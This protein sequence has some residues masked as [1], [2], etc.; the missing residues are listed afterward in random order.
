MKPEEV[1]QY[2]AELFTQGAIQQSSPESWQVEVETMRLL[3]LLSD[4][5]SWLRILAPLASAEEAQPFLEQL[6][7]ANFDLTQETRYALQ[8]G[9][10]WGMFQHSFNTLT[11]EDFK[12]AIARLVVLHQ[13]GLSGSF[14]Q[15][16]ELRIQQIIQAAK[17]QGQSL[18]TTLQNLDRFYEE[19][20]MGDMGQG[21]AAREEVLAAWRY[22]LE[23]LWNE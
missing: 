4:D 21:A 22:Q 7:E 8:Q 2:L 5:R 19:G 1:T 6:L 14:N 3:V 13:Q 23:R 20:L 12:S 11:E 10:L 9:A 15:F 17:Q 16:V 18:E